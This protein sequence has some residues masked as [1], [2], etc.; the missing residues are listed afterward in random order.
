M[1]CWIRGQQDTPRNDACTPKRPASRGATQRPADPGGRPRGVRRRSRCAH[2]RGG[3]TRRGRDRRPVPS[4]REQG[5]APS[6]ALLRGSSTIHRRGRGRAGRRRRPLG[7]LRGLHVPNRGRRHTLAD[8][9][10]GGNLH[11]NGGAVPG[12][13]EGAGTQLA[14]VRANQDG[15]R[16]PPRRRGGRPFAAFRASGR[17]S[18]R[19][20]EAHPPASS[21]VLGAALGRPSRPVGITAARPSTQLGGDQS[22]LGEPVFSAISRGTWKEFTVKEKAVIQY[23]SWQDG[24]GV[25]VSEIVCWRRVWR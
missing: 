4:L 21:P 25:A 8:A 6:A 10:L 24:I 18:Y 11:P 3:R 12:Q 17:R 14:A 1:L 20:R 22:A 23:L 19:G 5:G 7:R 2:L 15:G 9:T 13:S 16:H